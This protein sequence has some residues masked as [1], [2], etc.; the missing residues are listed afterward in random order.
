MAYQAQ[1]YKKD[2][3]KKCILYKRALEI[4]DYYCKLKKNKLER[5]KKAKEETLLCYKIQPTPGPAQVLFSL[6]W[7]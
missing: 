1:D 4:W 6:A 2:V 7:S 5:I 3:P